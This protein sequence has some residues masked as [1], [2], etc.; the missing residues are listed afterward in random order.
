MCGAKD[1][2]PPFYPKFAIFSAYACSKFSL[3]T[4]PILRSFCIIILPPHTTL[5]SRPNNPSLHPLNLNLGVTLNMNLNAD[6]DINLD[7]DLNV[8]SIVNLK[9]NVNVNLNVNLN[10]NLT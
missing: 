4:W 2:P 1:P 3:F 7:I 6:L 10:L 8:N 5:A 9:V